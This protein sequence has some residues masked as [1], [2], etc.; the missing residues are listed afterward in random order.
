MTIELG[1]IVLLYII[2]GFQF[3]QNLGFEDEDG[4]EVNPSVMQLLGPMLLWPA[5]VVYVAFRYRDDLPE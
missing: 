2:G 5:V 1:I 4:N 3:Y